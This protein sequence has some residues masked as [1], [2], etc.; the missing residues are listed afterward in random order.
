VG[1]L[2]VLVGF[3][4]AAAAI[5]ILLVPLLETQVGQLVQ[6]FPDYLNAARGLLNRL[7]ALAQ[8]RL[9]QGEMDKLRDAAG[10]Q[11]NDLMGGA[12]QLITG[13]LSGGVAVA[14]ILS[15]FILTPIV[16]F[17]MLRDWNV[18]I[19]TIDSWMPRQY[20]GTIREQA[21]LINETLTGF[22]RGQASVCLLFGAFYA[23]GLTLLGLDF[24]LV[25]GFMVGFMIFIPFIGGLSGAVVAT[26]LAFAQFGDWHKPVYVALLFVVGQT[27][28]GNV[29][30]PKLIGDRVHLH[31]VWL[32]FSLLAF[33]VLFG[34]I[35][36]LVA[37]PMAAVIG[38][39]VRFALRAY[40]ASP[41]YEPASDGV[42]ED[43][44]P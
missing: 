39:L 37:V 20:L 40:L 1:A 24:G 43:V 2:L 41:L 18:L 8:D 11:L 35:G 31:P 32:I 29:V 16:T 21:L 36:V 27:L 7:L 26:A 14:N 4:L 34:F 38:V 5:V 15:L 28:E 22:I 12:G 23:L 42:A 13:L 6:R 10:A 44:V 25:I 3:G 17:F 19:A 9:P 30:T 33:G